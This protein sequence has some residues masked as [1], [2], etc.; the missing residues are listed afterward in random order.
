ML[1]CIYFAFGRRRCEG[2]AWEMSKVDFLT[3]EERTEILDKYRNL[4]GLCDMHNDRFA[5]H[6]ESL[7]KKGV[8]FH[9][10]GMLPTM[11]EIIEVI[12]GPIAMNKCL[13]EGGVCDMKRT[14][15]CPIHYYLADVQNVVSKKLDTVNFEMLIEKYQQGKNN[16]VSYIREL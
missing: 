14:S 8:A 7:I 4:L 13:S 5:L 1:P 16:I 2:L 15:I 9:H 10:A 6:M 11:K 3:D 12:E